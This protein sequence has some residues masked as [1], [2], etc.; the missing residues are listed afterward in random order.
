MPQIL[1]IMQFKKSYL[2]SAFSIVTICVSAQKKAPENWFNLDPNDNKVYGVSTEKTYKELLKGKKS[3]PVIVAV[4]DGGTEV[5]HADLKNVIWHNSRE[6]A[7]NNKDDDKNGYIDDINGW[8]F[9]GGNDT[10]VVQ[11]NLE[12]TRIFNTYNQK[13]SGLAEGEVLS[14]EKD[15]FKLYKKAALLYEKKYENAERLYMV[16]SKI[17]ESILKLKTFLGNK[18]PTIALIKTYPAKEIFDKIAVDNVLI[19]VKQ[20][21][22]INDLLVEI[23]EGKNYFKTQLDYHLS[24]DFDSRKIIGD[25]Y[26]DLTESIYGNNYVSGPKGDHGTHVAGIIAATRNNS[27]GINGVAENAQIMVLRVVPDGDERDKDVANA[28]KYAVDNGAKIINMSFGKALSPNKTYVDEAIKYAMD[29]DVLVIHAAGNDNQ[30]IDT[31]ENYPTARFYN[32]ELSARAWIEVGASSWKQKKYLTATFSNY[33]KKTVDI[34][35][36]GVDIYSCIP[37]SKYATFNGTSMAAPVVA[38]MAAVLRSYFPEITA[39]QTKNLITE[40]AIKYNKKVFIP[41]TKVKVKLSDICITGGIANLYN[42]IQ[43]GVKKGY[44]LSEK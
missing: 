29:K 39:E 28:I 17:E 42:A 38:G 40:S 34:F 14:S 23:G 1:K 11:D 12:I 24:K 41:S 19:I 30:N 5:Y 4:I 21:K 22:S 18:K 25:N 3:N 27:E 7:G 32:S 8:N 6:I 26:S 43:L 16:Y 2:V 37:E 9:I 36:P 31:V 15:E 13:F 10:N 33:G 35:A 20:N 44:K